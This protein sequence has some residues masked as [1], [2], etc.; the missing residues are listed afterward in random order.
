LYRIGQELVNNAL[1]HSGAAKINLQLILESNRLCIQVI[2]ME[3]DLTPQ[4]KQAMARAWEVSAT[5][6]PPITANFEIWSKPGEG[7]EATIEFFST[8]AS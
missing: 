4:H 7:T 5:V 3:K 1:K 2:E 6:L 8:L